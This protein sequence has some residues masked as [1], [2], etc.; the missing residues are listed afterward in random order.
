MV[1]LSV[2]STKPEVAAAKIYFAIK[3]RQ[4]EVDEQ[5]LIVDNDDEIE[6]W[7]DGANRAFISRSTKH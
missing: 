4:R 7:K 3:T 2:D 1:A 5:D 6:Q